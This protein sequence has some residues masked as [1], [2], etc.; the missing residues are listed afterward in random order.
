MLAVN[1]VVMGEV[2]R[3]GTNR[4]LS[5]QDHSRTL[6]RLHRQGGALRSGLVLELVAG[7]CRKGNATQSTALIG[8]PEPHLTLGCMAVGAKVAT[9]ADEFEMQT[10]AGILLYA[11]A[12]VGLDIIQIGATHQ[13][14][15]LF[16]SAWMA[17][18][19]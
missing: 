4:P 12:L 16:A 3:H 9:A 2:R 7:S 18:A 14:I 6:L 15:L 19:L 5:P 11:L 13:L 8:S 17:A 1:D 10:L